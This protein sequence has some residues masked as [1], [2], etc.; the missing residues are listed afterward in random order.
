VEPT[1][2]GT[3]L[4]HGID[5]TEL[6]GV[7]HLAHG[8]PFRLTP[9]EL[10]ALSVVVGGELPGALTPAAEQILAWLGS[11]ERSSTAPTGGRGT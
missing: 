5:E 2:L 3:L 7:F 11:G 6:C 9:P 1:L 4:L 10:S 8:G